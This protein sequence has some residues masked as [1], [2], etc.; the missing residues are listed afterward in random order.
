MRELMGGADIPLDLV[1]ELI[2][3]KTKYLEENGE[4]LVDEM[5]EAAYD[6]TPQ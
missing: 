3:I 5:L 2:A 6:F 1:K 4:A